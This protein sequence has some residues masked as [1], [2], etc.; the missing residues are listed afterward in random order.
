LVRR[1][2]D[3]PTRHPE[4]KA[5]ID[6]AL[7]KTG[8][9]PH[10]F[11][12][13]RV[14]PATSDDDSVIERGVKLAL[15]KGGTTLEHT[16]EGVPMPDYDGDDPDAEEIWQYASDAY[17]AESRGDVYV[18]LGESLRPGNVWEVFVSRIYARV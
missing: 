16:I 10:F 4:L 7:K 12:S 15:S 6:R 18:V 9:R 5:T 1:A 11:W 3:W 8:A 17:A 2:S 14:L 13:G